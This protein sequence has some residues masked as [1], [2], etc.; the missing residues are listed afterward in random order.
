MKNIMCFILFVFQEQDTGGMMG[1]L[2]ASLFVV[3]ATLV[4]GPEVC[5]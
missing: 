3:L 1:H 5:R 4:V 2:V